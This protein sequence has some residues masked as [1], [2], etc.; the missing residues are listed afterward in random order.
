MRGRGSEVGN[1]SL[2][3]LRNIHARHEELLV[4]NPP[5]YYR[6]I[7]VVINAEQEQCEVLRDVARALQRETR[8][9]CDRVPVGV[10]DHQWIDDIYQLN[11]DLDTVEDRHLL[12]I[13]AN[14]RDERDVTTNP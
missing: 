5:P 2:A 4:K 3:Q 6:G 8:G 12:G 1:V 13:I 7:V 9:L 10:L 11:E 14:I